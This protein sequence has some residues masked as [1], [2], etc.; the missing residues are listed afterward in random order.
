MNRPRKK[1]KPGLLPPA[2]PGYCEQIRTMTAQAR[3]WV[4]A[5]P[6]ASPLVQFNYP[7]RT[8]VVCP[9]S[10]AAENHFITMNDDGRAMAEAACAGFTGAKEATILMLR[11][12]VEMMD[13]PPPVPPTCPACKITVRGIGAFREKGGEPDEEKEPPRNIFVL[14]GHCG[15]LNFLDRWGALRVPTER[16]VQKLEAGHLADLRATQARIR[17]NPL[18]PPP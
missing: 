14:C 11:V 15:A 5:H 10:S 3:A 13:E 16:E 6:A 12:A 7:S 9:L 18:P 1:K 2:P 17:A 4:D 8:M